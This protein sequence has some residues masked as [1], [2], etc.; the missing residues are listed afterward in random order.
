MF[1]FTCLSFY[2]ANMREITC[3]FH[4]EPVRSSKE[5]KEAK[6][7]LYARITYHSLTCLD[8]PAITARDTYQTWNYRKAIKLTIFA[9]F[10]LIIFNVREIKKQRV[11]W[12][13]IHRELLGE[14]LQWSIRHKPAK[15]G[16][17]DLCTLLWA[18]TSC[19]TPPHPVDNCFFSFFRYPSPP[20][21][22]AADASSMA[23]TDKAMAKSHLFWA[24]ICFLIGGKREKKQMRSEGTKKKEEEETE[25]FQ[26]MVW[27][28]RT[29][30]DWKYAK[31]TVAPAQAVCFLQGHDICH[32][33]VTLTGNCHHLILDC[34][35]KPLNETFLSV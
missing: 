28:N 8:I 7:T 20:L 1:N 33:T 11:V 24:P 21:D 31:T 13:I 12:C 27:D 29:E 35:K 14:M 5:K 2:E 32:T 10:Y 17:D 9:N 16:C 22:M 4:W 34:L 6:K 18:P 23:K 3:C 26:I 19:L 15:H 30:W 25:V